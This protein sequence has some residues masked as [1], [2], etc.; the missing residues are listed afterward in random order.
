[1]LPP[2]IYLHC[3]RALNTE[4]VTGVTT[5]CFTDSDNLDNLSPLEAQISCYRILLQNTGELGL[6][7]AVALQQR[8]LFF[9][10]EQDMA[11]HKLVVSN[12]DKKVVLEEAFDLGEVLDAGKRLAGGGGQG[13]VGD[14]DAR[15]VVVRDGVLCKLADLGDSKLLVGQE[16]DPDRAAVGNR[17]GV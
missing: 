7:E 3:G 8:N 12:V 14:H 16:L 15:L 5:S 11:G 10:G 17:V 1:M 6:L 4:S 2:R 13:H 9:A